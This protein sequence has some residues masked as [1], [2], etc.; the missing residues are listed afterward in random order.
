MY[1][2]VKVISW[3]DFIQIQTMVYTIKIRL[4]QMIENPVSNLILPAST[5]NSLS[6]LLVLCRLKESHG[7][8]SSATVQFYCTV[9]LKVA[10]HCQHL[11]RLRTNVKKIMEFM[12]ED[13]IPEEDKL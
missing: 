2:T 1:T 7:C 4:L 6:L 5:T 3:Y 8:C 10:A 13:F 12:H 9:L 11:S